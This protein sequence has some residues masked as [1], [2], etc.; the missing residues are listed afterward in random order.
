VDFGRSASPDSASGG[1]AGWRAARLSNF[2]NARFPGKPSVAFGFILAAIAWL[3]GCLS[4]F[5]GLCGEI[6]SPHRGLLF[7]SFLLLAA[8]RHPCE[9]SA[10]NVCVT[11]LVVGFWRGG[12][13]SQRVGNVLHQFFTPRAE[14]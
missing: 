8:V 3:F 1:D 7:A 14:I 11:S 9:L 5:S 4:L 10:S 13:E 12:I 2:F 6:N